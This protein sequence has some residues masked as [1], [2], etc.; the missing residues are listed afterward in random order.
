MHLTKLDIKGLERVRRLNIINSVTGVKPANLIGTTSTSTSTSKV[1]GEG[2]LSSGSNLAIFSSVIHL[3]SNPGLLGFIIRPVGDVPRHTYEN[4]LETGFYTINHVHIDFVEQA[5]KT[6]AKFDRATSE[7]EVCGFTEE[8]L[9][10]F[11]APFVKESPVKLGM[12]YVESIPIP[13]NGTALVIGEIE[14]IILPDE[15]VDENGY[16]DLAALNTAGISGLNRYYSLKRIGEFAYAR[17]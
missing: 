12:K 7:F 5:H 4:I 2:S 13:I 8:Y 3:G 1:G 10:G 9:S 17:V 11:S 16:I 6:S 14:H 15:G